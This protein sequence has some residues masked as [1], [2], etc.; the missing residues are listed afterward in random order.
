MLPNGNS[1]VYSYNAA[2]ELLS[3]TY[4]QGATVIGDLTYTYD[5][6]GNRIKQGGA[7]ARSTIPPA[8]ATATYNANNQQTIFGSNTLTYDFNG[9]LATVTDPGG[10]A[11]YSWNTRNQLAA[12]TATGFAASFSY[13]SFG[14]R[15]GKTI[16][17][18]TTNFVYDG[19]NP[20]QEKAGATVTANLL[21]SLGIDEFLTR[22][23]GAGIRGL[24]TDALG[25]TVALGDGT[26]TIQTQYTYEPFGYASQTGAANTSSYKYTGR[27]DDGSGLSYYRARYYHPRLQRFIAEDPLGFDGGDMN[28]YAYVLG[29]PVSLVDPLG[30][31]SVSLSGFAGPGASFTFGQN[32]NGSGF[33][34]LQFGFG[35]GGG[36]KYDPFGQQQGYSPYQG[37]AWGLGLGLYAQG[38]FNAGYIYAGAFTNVGRN[39]SACGSDPY[40]N[41]PTWRTGFRGAISG[42]NATAHAGGQITIFGGGKLKR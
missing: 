32:P 21:T 1:V 34:S 39:Y 42:I 4:K 26:G 11:T 40:A 16:Q 23:D 9:N 20:V 2:S 12:I 28:L 36:V 33:V 30:L 41:G 27:E 25:S 6:A 22:T 10:T 17:G 24:L 38:D 35:L 18:T 8:L 37:T 14:R 13:D 19:L 7:F 3:L 29:D 31:W 15:T 5:A